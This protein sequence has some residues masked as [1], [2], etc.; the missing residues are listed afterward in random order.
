[1]AMKSAGDMRPIFGMVPA[2]QRLEARDRAVLQPHDRLVE[3]RDLLALDGAAQ[4][5]FEREPVGLARAHRGL[6]HLDAVAADALGMVHRELGVLEDLLAAVRLRVVER[7]AHRGG[8]EDLAVV[9]G[10]RRAQRPP[11]R[12]GEGDDA[13]GIAL[14]EEDERELVAGEARERVLRLQQPSEP[15]RE[16]EQDRDR[17]P[18]CRPS[19]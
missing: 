8:Q 12:L 4:L 11:Q 5:R 2:R 7:D 6:E 18:R 14:G 16:R 15:A 9:E 19:R 1:M 10:D 17:R 13:L 3:D